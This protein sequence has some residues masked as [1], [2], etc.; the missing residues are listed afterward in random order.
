MN[1]HTQAPMA[2]P[3]RARPRITDDWIQTHY[4]HY[5]AVL[6]L[7][8]LAEMT[9][10]ARNTVRKWMREPY[11]LPARRSPYVP[12]K[13]SGYVDIDRNT[14]VRLWLSRT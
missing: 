6:T 12:G 1:T 3:R 10:R 11:F 8:R 2:S 5:P 13:P 9:G 7:D 14:F 4:G